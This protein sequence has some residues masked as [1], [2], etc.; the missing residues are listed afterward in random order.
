MN[1]KRVGTVKVGISFEKRLCLTDKKTYLKESFKR[2]NYNC[3]SG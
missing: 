1:K 3:F 2:M